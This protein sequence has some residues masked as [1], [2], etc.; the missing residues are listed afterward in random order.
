VAAPRPCR[1]VVTDC[2][3]SIRPTLACLSAFILH[4]SK[5]RLSGPSLGTPLTVPRRPAA[6]QAGRRIG[7]GEPRNGGRADGV[8]GAL[9][10]PPWKRGSPSVL[11]PPIP[12]DAPCDSR[13]FSRHDKPSRQPSDLGSWVPPTRVCSAGRGGRGRGGGSEGK[14]L[15]REIRHSAGDRPRLVSPQ[16]KQSGEHCFE[17]GL[18][19]GLQE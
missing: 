10:G 18:A 8:F 7:S 12:L 2:N 14:P 17:P 16:S 5:R 19:E 15:R 1:N 4:C 13:P 11:P 9:Q 3:V 6:P